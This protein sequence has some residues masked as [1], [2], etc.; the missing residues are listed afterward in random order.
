[1]TV[2]KL[3][4]VCVILS[5]QLLYSKASQALT[6]GDERTGE[7]QVDRS[8]GGGYHRGGAKWDH[9]DNWRVRDY[10]RK[11]RYEGLGRWVMLPGLVFTNIL[12]L[13]IVLF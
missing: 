4:S 8:S 2:Y 13:R 1:M 7:Y 12:I 3:L 9:R 5:T 10:Q 6:Q 11:H